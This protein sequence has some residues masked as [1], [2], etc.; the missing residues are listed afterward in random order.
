MALEGY[1]ALIDR[2]AVILKVA[3]MKHTPFASN[4]IFIFLLNPFTTDFSR[5]ITEF[6]AANSD[7]IC[8]ALA[9]RPVYKRTGGSRECTTTY[10]EMPP[11]SPDGRHER[12]VS[13]ARCCRHTASS[14]LFLLL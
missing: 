6:I 12:L 3:N 7:D 5:Q 2:A 1:M 11:S 14:E 4:F 10:F 9:Y 13:K 8:Y